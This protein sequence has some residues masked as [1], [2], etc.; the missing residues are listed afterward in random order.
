MTRQKTAPTSVVAAAA[1]T[2]TNQTAAELDG[3]GVQHPLAGQPQVTADRSQLAVE[4]AV[5]ISGRSRSTG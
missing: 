2:A 5:V 1:Q 3:E 4:A